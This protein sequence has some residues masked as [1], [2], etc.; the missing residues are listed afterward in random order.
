MDLPNHR[1]YL[2]ILSLRGLG[3]SFIRQAYL[4]TWENDGMFI[5]LSFIT[6]LAP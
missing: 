4:F 5:K 6:D 1:S 3:V 2:D